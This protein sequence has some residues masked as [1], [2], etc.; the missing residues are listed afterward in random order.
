[1]VKKQ[2]NVVDLAEFDKQPENIETYNNNEPDIEK[3]KE[4]I[5]NEEIEQPTVNDEKPK[6]KPRAKKVKEEPQPEITEEIKEEIQ[7]ITSEEKQPAEEEK[8]TEKIKKIKTV[9]LV[10][11]DKC[12]KE[13]TKKALRYSHEKTCTGK[14]INR[15]D[16]PVKR[17]T[18][19]K[20]INNEN[21]NININIPQ[22]IIENEI[23]K[24]INNIKES[25]IKQKEEKI[26]KLAQNIV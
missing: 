11:C 13:L 8:P 3:I 15:E 26:K 10:K 14:V 5:K 25:R 19:P 22:E 1:M 4:E 9:E 17:R 12:G 23:N 16:I 7:Q 18:T 2:I 21:N 6:R 24:R 20:K